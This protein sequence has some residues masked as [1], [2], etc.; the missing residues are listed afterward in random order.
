MNLKSI[1][2][3]FSIAVAIA[4]I[5]SQSFAQENL[6]QRPEGTWNV[7]LTAAEVGF[8]EKERYTFITG[9]SRKEGS[10]IFSNE[11]DAIPPCGTDQ[12]VWNQTGRGEFALTHGAFCIDPESQNPGFAIKFRETI[13]LDDSGESFSGRGIFEVFDPE[14]TLLFSATYTLQG[15]RMQIERLPNASQLD[16]ANPIQEAREPHSGWRTWSQKSSLR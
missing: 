11:V 14:G 10:L 13:M 2:L 5:P 1:F 4:I 9:R 7:I 6:K 8:Q 12:G 3:A 15:T 16:G